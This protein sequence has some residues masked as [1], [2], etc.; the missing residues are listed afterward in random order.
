MQLRDGREDVAI[1]LGD[2]VHTHLG[3]TGGQGCGSGEIERMGENPRC[4]GGE[5]NVFAGT[6]VSL[7][8]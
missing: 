3:R 7:L 1:S 6:L 4:V 5:L 2:S 8:E